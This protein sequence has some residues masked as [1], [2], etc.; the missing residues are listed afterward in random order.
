MLAPSPL[1]KLNVQAPSIRN[2]YTLRDKK[3]I[4]V[5]NL[6]GLNSSLKEDLPHIWSTST[7]DAAR[8][9]PST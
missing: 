6:E 9:R 2:L 1:Q 5:M 4:N 8:K 7:K 3:E